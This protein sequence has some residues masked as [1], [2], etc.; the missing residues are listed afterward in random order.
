MK[1]T[2]K[3]I[4]IILTGPESTGKTTLA[5][6]LSKFYNTKWYPEFARA[7]IAN[8]NRDYTFE[9]V[10]KISK[11]QIETFKNIED[12]DNKFVFF[13]TGLII[14]KI[15]FKERYKKVPVFLEDAINLINFDLHLLCYPDIKWVSD[16]V[17]ENGG[18]KRIDLF[19]KYKEELEKK[20][21]NYFIIKGNEEDRFASAKKIISSAYCL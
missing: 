8:L 20:S 18:A 7:Y 14:S 19:Y 2:S 11:K 16:K 15:W 3:T 21:F 17:R 12:V 4:K 6:Q 9:D 5:Q 10:V 1:N 13:D